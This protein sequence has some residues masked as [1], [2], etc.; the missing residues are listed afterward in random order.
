MHTQS[1][2]KRKKY[3]TEHFIAASLKDP[4]AAEEL[5]MHIK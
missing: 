5:G 2:N 1:V 4:P 3:G